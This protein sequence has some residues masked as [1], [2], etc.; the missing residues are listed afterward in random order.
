VEDRFLLQQAILLFVITSV[1]LPSALFVIALEVFMQM[2]GAKKI[3]P[4]NPFIFVTARLYFFGPSKI[5]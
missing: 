5:V 4:A 2:G 3:T 1:V